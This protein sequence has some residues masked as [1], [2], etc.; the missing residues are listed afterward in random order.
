MVGIRL[1]PLYSN[2]TDKRAHETLQ[3]DLGLHK[4]RGIT[5][6]ITKHNLSALVLPTDFTLTWAANP[7]LPAVTV[8]FGTYLDGIFLIKGTRELIAVAPGIPFGMAFWA[9]SGAKRL[10]L[11]WHMLIIS[12]KEI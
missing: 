8:P 3:A 9:R 1:C 11:P 4:A 12:S 5:S 7:G 10:L 2:A 6:I